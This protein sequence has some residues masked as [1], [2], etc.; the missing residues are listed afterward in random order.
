MDSFM[1]NIRR[2]QCQTNSISYRDP[3]SISRK[4][5]FARAQTWIFAMNMLLASISV[6]GFLSGDDNIFV[7]ADIRA[8]GLRGN[9]KPSRPRGFSWTDEKMT[10]ERF[11]EGWR[12]LFSVLFSVCVSMIQRN[13]DDRF[14]TDSDYHFARL[15]T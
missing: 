9:T 13:G 4:P 1:L 6:A 11:W 8:I 10:R 3:T 7:V 12:F 14:G 15:Q 5:F 2:S